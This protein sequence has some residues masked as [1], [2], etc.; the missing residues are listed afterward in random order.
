MRVRKSSC[1]DQGIML[2]HF[3]KD[4]IKI[5]T[6]VLESDVSSRKNDIGNWVINNYANDLIKYMRELIYKMWL[7]ESESSN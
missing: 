2:K 5:L 4:L 6:E 3:I 7:E 1:A